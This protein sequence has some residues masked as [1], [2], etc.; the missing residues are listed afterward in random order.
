MLRL[1]ICHIL[2]ILYFFT[3]LFFRKFKNRFIAQIYDEMFQFRVTLHTYLH[4]KTNKSCNLMFTHIVLSLIHLQTLVFIL[5]FLSRVK[6]KCLSWIFNVSYV[7][8]HIWTVLCLKV[9]NHRGFFWGATRVFL[10]ILESKLT[11]FRDTIFTL[12]K[13]T[14]LMEWFYYLEWEND[15][16][17]YNNVRR[18]ETL[19]KNKGLCEKYS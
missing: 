12:Q 15:V 14:K 17:D 7:S 19:G 3:T 18:F 13:F 6:W 5:K 2:T 16:C 4:N 8:L 10:F 1:H 11:F 9:E